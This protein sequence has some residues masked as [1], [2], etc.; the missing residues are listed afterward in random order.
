[1]D[2]LLPNGDKLS[3]ADGATGADAAAAIGPGL[4]K[5]ALAIKVDGVAYD[6]ARP[7]PAGGE[8]RIEIIT[9]KSGEEALE[10]IRHDAAHVF[11]ESM[12]ELYPGVKISIGPPI[13]NG[14]YYDVD[15]PDGVTLS[16]ADFLAIEARMREHIDADEEFV[17]EDVTVGEALERYT[18]DGQDYKV[19]LIEDLVKNAPADTPVTGVSL[20]TN[21]DFVDLCRGPH[22]PSTKRIKAFKLQSVAGAYWRGDSNNKMLTRVYGTAFF[23]NRDL[24]DYLERLERARQNDHRRLG[25]LLGMFGFSDTAPGSAFWFPPGAAVFNEL[26]KLSREMGVP[27]GYTEVKTP[28]LFDSSLWKTSGHWDK[29]HDD[30]FI[31]ESEDRQMALKPMNCPGHC[32]LYLMQPHS[33]RDLPVRYSE[34]GLLH[35]NEPSG[36]LHGLLRVRHFAQDDAHVFC[37]EDQIQDEVAGVLQFAFDTYRLFGLDVRLELSTRPD[38]RIGSDELWDKSEQAL[39]NALDSHGL[40]YTINEGDGAFYGPKIDIHMTDSL[41]RSW[42]LGTCQLDYNFPERFHLS[43]TGADNA[44]HQPVM[45]HRA[46]M[47]SYERFIG[48]LLEHFG[49]ELPIWLAPLQVIVLPIADRHNDYAASVQKRL[50]AGGVRAELDDRTESVGRKI[51]D[52]EVRKAPFM[53]VV[54]DREQE[55]GEVGVREHRAGDTGAVPIEEFVRRITDLIASRA[56]TSEPRDPSESEG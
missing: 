51:R 13:E 5:A 10:L 52:A 49:G 14:F 1:V 11:A 24:E 54:G 44:E 53:L 42:Q 25:P 8:G 30:M 15:L 47:G 20:Y 28:Q 36:T 50:S 17:R 29:Y 18:R 33:Y 43:Y 37:T 31:T 26:V 32:Q 7:L 48:I 55:T 27:R 6:L 41:G 12:L 34:P 3:L 21:G 45:I 22:A 35:R 19:E 2:Y 39:K 4:A 9:E 56:L 23:S 40:E 46:L 38:K 16:E